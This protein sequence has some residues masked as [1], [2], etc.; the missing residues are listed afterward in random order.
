MNYNIIFLSFLIIIQADSVGI[1]KNE[2]Y[3]TCYKLD[4][5]GSMKCKQQ[6][7]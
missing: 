1:D 5:E 4:W 2:H 3:S 6:T 7:L